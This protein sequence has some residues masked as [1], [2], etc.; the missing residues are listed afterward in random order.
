MFVN[1]TFFF[2]IIIL[3]NACES[4]NSSFRDGNF[5]DRNYGHLDY[6]YSKE[7]K[8][9]SQDIKQSED[10][11]EEEQEISEENLSP[12]IY[13]KNYQGYYKIGEA[14][15]VF[16]IEYVP[17]KYNYL[18]ETGEASWY[19]P[20]FH[21]K[22]TANGEIFDMND[23][24]AAHR[25]MPLPSIAEVTNLENGKVIK[26]RIND[27]GPFIHDRIMDLS[28][29]SAEMLDFKDQGVINVRVKYLA[30]ETEEL[31]QNLGLK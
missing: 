24:T 20:K 12:E 15:K 1:I 5:A 26:V 8:E 19:G 2:T 17:Q 31:L 28:R 16:G 21:G 27:R 30:D 4:Q 3:L 29:K 25:T 23:I 11:Y 10:N 22:L 7:I 6:K 14:Y 9:I 13:D 18:E